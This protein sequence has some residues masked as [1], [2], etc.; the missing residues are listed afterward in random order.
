MA[1]ERTTI[2]NKVIEKD[3]SNWKEDN[4][5]R[6]AEV[7]AATRPQDAPERLDGASADSA[8]DEAFASIVHAR[9]S[10]S[11]VLFL[12]LAIERVICAGPEDCGADEWMS[13]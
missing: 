12:L 5:L 1:L 6:K 9:C 4:K 2:D 10:N 11:V 13:Q 3:S 8:L 7:G